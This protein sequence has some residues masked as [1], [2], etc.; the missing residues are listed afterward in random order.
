MRFNSRKRPRAARVPRSLTL[1]PFPEKQ[2]KTLT[3]C[4]SAILT[5]A[6]DVEV[7]NYELRA[8]SIWDPN[9]SETGHKPYG[10]T[11]FDSLY[12]NYSVKTA[13]IDVMFGDYNAEGTTAHWPT[14]CGVWIN[15]DGTEITDENLIREQP[16]SVSK[17]LTNNDSVSIRQV[18]KR[19]ARY[20]A[21]GQSDQ[22]ALFGA[23]PSDLVVFNIF[24]AKDSN[25]S[26]AQSLVCYYKITYEVEM[27]DPK[28]LASS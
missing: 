9:A 12:T 25:L 21:F 10:W 13:I 11:T 8:N 1:A 22:T 16:G 2:T 3:Y 17:I 7:K 23:S 6:T 4:D 27:W 24:T 15:D 18:Y 19:N 5:T 20:P 28:K 14:M 26:N